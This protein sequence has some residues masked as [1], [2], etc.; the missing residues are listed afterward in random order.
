MENSF[1]SEGGF[2]GFYLLTENEELLNASLQLPAFPTA[3]I[4][5]YSDIPIS[6]FPLWLHIRINAD[7]VK[8]SIDFLSIQNDLSDGFF[9]N[10]AAHEIRIAGANGE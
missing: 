5:L 9:L 2:H 3:V 7:R 8:E 6:D 1:L 10:H 4:C